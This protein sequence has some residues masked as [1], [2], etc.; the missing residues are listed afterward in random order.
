VT[1]HTRFGHGGYF[2]VGGGCDGRD[3]SKGN[4]RRSR[5]IQTGARR[6]RCDVRERGRDIG[7]RGDARVLYD[8]RGVRHVKPK[9]QLNLPASPSSLVYNQSWPLTLYGEFGESVM[10]DD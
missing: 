2:V 4:P 5:L 8:Q 1:N 3:A 10:V 9:Q 7:A 6:S